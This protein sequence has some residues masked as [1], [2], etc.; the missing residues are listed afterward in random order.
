MSKKLCKGCFSYAEGLKNHDDH[1]CA[2]IRRAYKY[3]ALHLIEKCPCNS[4][5]IKAMCHVMCEDY[6]K[7][8]Y[9][10]EEYNNDTISM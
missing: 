8:C 7:R 9:L 4:C 1:E 3:K 5:L 10:I 6:A 2:V